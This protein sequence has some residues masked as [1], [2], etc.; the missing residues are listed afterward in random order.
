MLKPIKLTLLFCLT[1]ILTYAHISTKEKNALLAIYNATQGD[2]WTQT[3]DLEA[4]VSTWQGL[5]IENNSVV[6]LD[7]S[8]NNL[9]SIPE[10]FKDHII[11][12]YQ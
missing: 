4:D 11:L 1:S 3:W 7:L 2:Y 10:S 5:T 6:A 12:L 8:F 9:T